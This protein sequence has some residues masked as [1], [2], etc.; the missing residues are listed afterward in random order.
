MDKVGVLTLRLEHIENM[1]DEGKDWMTAVRR[2]VRLFPPEEQ[3]KINAFI[4]KR[5]RENVR[6]LLRYLENARAEL[7]KTLSTPAENAKKD[8]E[9]VL[10]MRSV[11]QLRAFVAAVDQY[12]AQ[13]DVETAAALLDYEWETLEKM[14]E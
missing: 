11:D 3:K 10:A 14:E 4:A 9:I 8:E 13:L 12:V 7:Q 6:S 5:Q 1:R 2:V